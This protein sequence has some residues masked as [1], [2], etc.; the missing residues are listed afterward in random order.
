M[1]PFALRQLDD[2]GGM[3]IVRGE[4]ERCRRVVIDHAARGLVRPGAHVDD[5]R[6]RIKIREVEVEHVLHA[7]P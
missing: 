5:V 2:G 7:S 1:E 6:F 4:P 3:R